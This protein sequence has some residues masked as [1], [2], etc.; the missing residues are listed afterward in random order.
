M[1]QGGF[2]R[3]EGCLC[4]FP[5]LWRAAPS[6]PTSSAPVPM[7]AAACTT[8]GLLVQKETCKIRYSHRLSE[9]SL[10]DFSAVFLG[11]ES[12]DVGNC[13]PRVLRPGRHHLPGTDV[14]LYLQHC[15]FSL[16]LLVINSNVTL[17]ITLGRFWESHFGAGESKRKRRD[18]CSSLLMLPGWQICARYSAQ[19][20]CPIDIC[21]WVCPGRDKHAEQWSVNFTY[22]GSPCNCMFCECVCTDVSAQP[23]VFLTLVSFWRAFIILLSYI[24]FTVNNCY[25]WSN[26]RATTLNK[27]CL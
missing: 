10:A 11:L 22:Q 14:A 16:L 12:E 19:H 7:V 5:K 3:M 2:L 27:V 15:R 18:D 24:I 23:V 21:C 4:A 26:L 13:I 1:W 17:Y 20:S 25:T 6:S 8:W 9:L